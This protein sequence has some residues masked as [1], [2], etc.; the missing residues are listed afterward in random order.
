MRQKYSPDSSLADK[1]DN[2]CSCIGLI[3]PEKKFMMILGYLI[4]LH[5]Y[6][7]R[8]NVRCYLLLDLQEHIESTESF[9][10]TALLQDRSDFLKY[11]EVQESMTEQEFFAGICNVS[12][13]RELIS[14]IIFQFEKDLTNQR[15]VEP[16]FRKGYRDKGTL[17]DISLAARNQA[18][19]EDFYLYALQ[20]IIEERRLSRSAL[21]SSLLAYLRGTKE[22]TDQE[23]MLFR[24]KPRQKGGNLIDGIFRKTRIETYVQS[25]DTRI[26]EEEEREFGSYDYQSGEQD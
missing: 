21:A 13:L 17:P 14:H 9:W 4:L 16:T 25:R 20:S 19:R 23:L 18:I 26:F 1:Q 6:P 2:D 11:L 24:I 8:A 7:V 10:L 5:Y 22:L 12:K 15:V 3:F